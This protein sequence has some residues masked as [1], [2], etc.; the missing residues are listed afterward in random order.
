MLSHHEAQPHMGAGTQVEAQLD[1]GM[2]LG[3]AEI[4]LDL[5]TFSEASRE[6]ARS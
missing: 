2:R 6:D 1:V 4:I 3:D 5:I